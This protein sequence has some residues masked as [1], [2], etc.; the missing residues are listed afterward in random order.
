MVL[1]VVPMLLRMPCL[2]WCYSADSA[3]FVCKKW[4]RFRPAQ[5]GWQHTALTCHSARMVPVCVVTIL[6][7][8]AWM[9]QWL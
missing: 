8:T 5:A 4:E 6:S 1:S 9:G 3:C 2:P 7:S